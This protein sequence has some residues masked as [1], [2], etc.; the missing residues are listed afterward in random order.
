MEI[1]GTVHPIIHF[2]PRHSYEAQ[3]TEVKGTPPM[4]CTP[5]RQVKLEGALGAQETPATKEVQGDEGQ[6]TEM[7]SSSFLKQSMQ[8]VT[9][10]VC[11]FT[12]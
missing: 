9:L 6:P 2:F 8:V 5:G 4:C 1:K 12:F 10:V 3:D 11:S 7:E